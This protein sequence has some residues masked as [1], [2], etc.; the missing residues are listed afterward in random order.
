MNQGT[1]APSYAHESRVIGGVAV[2]LGSLSAVGGPARIAVVGSSWSGGVLR[3]G[4]AGSLAREGEL[5][6]GEPGKGHPGVSEKAQRLHPHLLAIGRR[7]LDAFPIHADGAHLAARASTGA[8]GGEYGH[9]R[10]QEQL[11][12]EDPRRF[13][14]IEREHFLAAEPARR[15]RALRQDDDDDRCRENGPPFGPQDQRCE[16]GNESRGEEP[17][18]SKPHR[19]RQDREQGGRVS[20][21][22]S[23]AGR[24][25]LRWLS[26]LLAGC[27]SGT[28]LAGC[29]DKSAA[30]QREAEN[31]SYDRL[32]TRSLNTCLV[33][34]NGK[35]QCFSK[36]DDKSPVVVQ[37][38]VG[39]GPA[40]EVQG[41]P[42]TIC[43]LLRDGQLRCWGEH[44][45]QKM[46]TPSLTSVP[47]LPPNLTVK[48]FSSH[49]FTCALLSDES[50]RCANP[51]RQGTALHFGEPLTFGSDPP[52]GVSAGFLTCVLR[53]SGSVVCHGDGTA[54]D[55]DRQGRTIDLGGKHARALSSGERHACAVLEDDRVVC[56]RD[57]R[58]L[59]LGQGQ[60]L[61]A[62][63]PATGDGPVEVSLGKVA[64]IRGISAG[65]AHTCVWFEDGKMKC[66]GENDYGQLGLGDLLSRGTKPDQMGDRLPI[67]DVGHDA[68]V[69]AVASGPIT[70]CALLSDGRVKC[71]GYAYTPANSEGHTATGD[72]IP[73]IPLHR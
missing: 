58:Q 23:R 2:R 1:L 70:T 13:V 8:P 54:G 47:S 11:D 64:R 46:T 20:R 52:V 9:E 27:L 53:R 37:E 51:P 69:A 71:W 4:E 24:R 59:L 21:V 62:G 42:M 72:K 5:G 60:L 3:V 41:D 16:V 22:C 14:P 66:W 67:V 30:R 7:K 56:W 38:I 73:S 33:L 18:G 45:G 48:R 68:H 61:W 17:K 65:D 19:Y 40:L 44:T 32:V 31:P 35:V 10:E 50:M 57:N 39:I 36:L 6:D 15:D 43:A 25:E 12:D 26:L 29:R 55:F 49:Y 34:E 63:A 28:L